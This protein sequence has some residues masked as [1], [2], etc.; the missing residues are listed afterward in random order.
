M[1]KIFYLLFALT[2]SANGF[3]QITDP[4]T[5]AGAIEPISTFSP[6][7]C[8]EAQGGTS[9]NKSIFTSQLAADNAIHTFLTTESGYA[10]PTT[11]VAW[12]D[13][14]S[15]NMWLDGS[16]GGGGIIKHEFSTEFTTGPAT[17]VVAAINIHQVQINCGAICQDYKIMLKSGGT[18]G[19]NA[20]T[21]ALVT[22]SLDPSVKY[23]QYTV[24]P[25]TTYII[26]RQVYYDG[27]DI[28]CFFSWTGTDGISSTGAKITAQHWFIWSST[29]LPIKNLQLNARQLT[30][31]VMLQWTTDEEINTAAY[32]VEK[33]IDAVNFI[34]MGEVSAAGNSY[35]Q[36]SY[37][38]EDKT[39]GPINFY[40]IKAID[41]E[42]RVTFSTVSKLILQTTNNT[43]LIVSSN[44][45][46]NQI[47]IIAESKTTV[48]CNYKITNTSGQ[49]IQSG[50][51]KVYKGVN[52]IE[53]NVSRLPA[54]I[55]LLSIQLN[56]Q[57]NTSKFVKE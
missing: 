20:L 47:N 7:N 12:Q 51:V 48:N 8:G 30:N 17:T 53:Q 16:A 5:G 13:V 27:N 29:T 45:V 31:T 6:C 57:I 46:K 56:E 14:R 28:D 3:A 18:C 52:K 15:S 55:Y 23:R 4:C 40:R 36:K 38:Q 24:T 50:I 1:K 21:P 42:G 33:S 26:S 32:E 39:P 10:L 35:T 54:G 49:I 43:T 44:P 9:C 41:K 34:K 37:W 25:N 11:P 19:V 2:F 22:S